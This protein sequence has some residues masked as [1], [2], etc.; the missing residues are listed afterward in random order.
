MGRRVLYVSI[1]ATLSRRRPHQTDGSPGPIMRMTSVSESSSLG[2]TH[3]L[4]APKSSNTQ[5]RKIL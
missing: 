1:Q 2:P 5:R 4:Q 3:T